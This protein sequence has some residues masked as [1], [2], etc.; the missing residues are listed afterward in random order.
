MLLSFVSALTSASIV[1]LSFGL[2]AICLEKKFDINNF[3]SQKR[4]L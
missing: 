3:H 4:E 2:D 1:P